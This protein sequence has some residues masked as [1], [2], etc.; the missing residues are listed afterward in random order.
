MCMCT[1][2][3]GG[4]PGLCPGIS[5]SLVMPRG[6]QQSKNSVQN[7]KI[8]GF[9]G[10]SEFLSDFKIFTEISRSQDFTEI[11]WDLTKISWDFTKILID[12]TKILVQII[13]FMGSH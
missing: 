13:N 6:Q 12:F 7:L 1:A 8:S 11:S 4:L 5:K 9:H 2:W 3:V 10:I